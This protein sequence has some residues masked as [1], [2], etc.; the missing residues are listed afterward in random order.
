MNYAKQHEH[1]ET[2]TAL[3]YSYIDCDIPASEKR[4]ARERMAKRDHNNPD[5]TLFD[6]DGENFSLREADK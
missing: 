3:E 6:F 1:T 4:K 5:D 2:F